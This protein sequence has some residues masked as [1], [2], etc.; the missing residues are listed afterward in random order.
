MQNGSVVPI[1]IPD[2]PERQQTP[3]LP[4]G[5]GK[6]RQSRSPTEMMS[7]IKS[8]S[9]DGGIPRRLKRKRTAR[10]TERLAEEE[11]EEDGCALGQAVREAYEALGRAHE[12]LLL[13]QWKANKALSQVAGRGSSGI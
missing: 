7:A 3:T 5:K 11:Q 8:G 1:E 10:S 4:K 13:A 12:H 6:V 9:V 2:S